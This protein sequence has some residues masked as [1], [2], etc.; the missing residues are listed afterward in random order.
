MVDWLYLVKKE[1]KLSIKTIRPQ[2]DTVQTR[3]NIKFE[4]T[5]PGTPQRNGKV[6]RAFATLFGKTRSMLNAARITIPLRKG[7]WAHCAELSVQRENVIVKEKH[8]Q[9][10]SE[11]VYGQNPK[12]ISNM[13][14][15]VEMAIVARHSDKK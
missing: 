10:A 2:I 7:L 12:W 8:Q 3:F 6:E 13:R 4:F 9:S 1:L 5:A 15:F 11:K 14:T